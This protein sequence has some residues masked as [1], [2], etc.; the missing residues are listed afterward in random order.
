MTFAAKAVGVHRQTASAQ[1]SPAS[2]RL[3]FFIL[4]SLSGSASDA[5]ALCLDD[6]HHLRNVLLAGVVV[7]GLH[8][9][10]DHRLGA[11]LPDK[12]AAGIAQCLGHRLDSGL[13]GSIV[14]RSLLSVTRTFSSTCG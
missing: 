14:L 8:H 12:D 5:V 13:H 3:N 7:G 9:H 2:I 4:R 11:G 1:A 6:I 10:T